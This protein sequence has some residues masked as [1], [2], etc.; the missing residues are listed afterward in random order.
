M[1]LGTRNEEGDLEFPDLM[2]PAEVAEAFNVDIKTVS[3]W[4]NAGLIEAIRTP[5]GHR[6]YL[7]ASVTAFFKQRRPAKAKKK[8]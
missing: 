6:R 2:S 4:A 1:A 3:R 7:T 8:S 5:G